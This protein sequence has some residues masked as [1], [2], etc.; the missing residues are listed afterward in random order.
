LPEITLDEINALAKKWI[1]DKNLAMIVLVKEGEGIIV[2]KEE[3][4]LAVIKSTREK[5]YEAYVDE[6]SEESLMP[7][8]PKSSKI[9]AR[10]ENQKF[11]TTEL[12]FGNQ[13]KSYP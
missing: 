10:T 5:K 6:D 11:G 13:V 2:P 7:E 3:D 12:T 4:L 1:T 9:I 8:M